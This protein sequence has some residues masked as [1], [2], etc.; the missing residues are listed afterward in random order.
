MTEKKNNQK[1]VQAPY[2]AGSET[3]FLGFWSLLKAAPL[4][5]MKNTVTDKVL[6]VITPLLSL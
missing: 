6:W 3:C 5:L 2:P 1:T 4:S